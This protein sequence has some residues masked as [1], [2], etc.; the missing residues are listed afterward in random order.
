LLVATA[1]CALQVKGRPF[2]ERYDNGDNLLFKQADL[3]APTRSFLFLDLIRSAEPPIVAL[4]DRLLTALRG[5]LASV[6]LLEE[7]MPEARRAVV[8]RQG[9][10]P[11]AASAP[12]AGRS[13]VPVA[14]VAVMRPQRA[15][16]AARAASPRARRRRRSPALLAAAG[17]IAVVGLLSAAGC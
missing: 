13:A 10:R 16:R 9:R 12:A 17:G 4:A 11:P 3:D 7:A 1:L 5:G 15:G 8:S 6:P 2:W 14:P